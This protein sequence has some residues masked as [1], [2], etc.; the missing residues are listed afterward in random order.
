MDT[1]NKLFISHIFSKFVIS[2]L[3]L[4]LKN[5]SSVD[6]YYDINKDIDNPTLIFN[7]SKVGKEYRL[8]RFIESDL[9][10]TY[11]LVGYGSYQND[12]KYKEIPEEI[13]GN[14]KDLLSYINFNKRFK[15]IKECI[16]LDNIDYDLLVG[17]SNPKKLPYNKYYLDTNDTFGYDQNKIIKWAVEDY[18]KVFKHALNYLEINYKEVKSEII[19]FYYGI[20]FETKVNSFGQ[21]K[22]GVCYGINTI[23][24]EK[25]AWD[26]GV[27][28]GEVQKI[29]RKD[30]NPSSSWL[31]NNL[32]N[33]IL[34]VN[35]L[36]KKVFVEN[37]NSTH[38][39]KI[40]DTKNFTD[41]TDLLIGKNVIHGGDP[42]Y[43]IDNVFESEKEIQIWITGSLY[44]KSQFPN[45]DNIEKSSK[46]ILFNLDVNI[47]SKLRN[48]GLEYIILSYYGFREMY[49]H[50]NTYKHTSMNAWRFN[51]P[52]V[53]NIIDERV[54]YYHLRNNEKLP[55][56][57]IWLNDD[58]LLV[59]VEPNKLNNYYYKVELVK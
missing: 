20:K 54:E 49:V 58:S 8:R 50:P 1:K 17:D 56:P 29:Y 38:I 24:L 22:Y 30:I 5:L 39:V 28:I 43:I 44:L 16:N 15:V 7:I 26:N 35:I 41:F 46:E 53:L 31:I 21:I 4:I 37:K 10:Y 52:I 3:R 42:T 57:R 6:I 45:I 40:D 19:W 59:E 34:A 51:N 48:L 13:I 23:P 18:L 2:E 32:I 9:L 14:L 27:L 11:N 12:F 33:Y 55:Y 25:V 47:I 36:N